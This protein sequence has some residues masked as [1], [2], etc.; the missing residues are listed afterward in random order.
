M[1]R[2]NSEHNN[3]TT[4]KTIKQLKNKTAQSEKAEH[5][6]QESDN[7]DEENSGDKRENV[8]SLLLKQRGKLEADSSQ[9]IFRRQISGMFR[10][11]VRFW[12]LINHQ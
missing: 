8:K 6:S 7:T 9:G 5:C 11:L 10:L 2:P 3:P 4:I 1:L 12:E